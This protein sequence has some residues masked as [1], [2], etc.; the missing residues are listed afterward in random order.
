M[1]GQSSHINRAKRFTENSA[2]ARLQD[3]LRG[4]GQLTP[5]TYL[6]ETHGTLSVLS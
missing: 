5:K 4:W 2:M 3:I 6:S 1:L